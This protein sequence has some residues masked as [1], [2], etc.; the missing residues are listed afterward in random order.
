MT[1]GFHPTRCEPCIEH[2]EPVVGLTDSYEF[3]AA[4]HQQQEKPFSHYFHGKGNVLDYILASAHFN[5]DCQMSKVKLL[6]YE[7]YAAHL[8]PTQSTEDI[9]VSDHSAIAIKIHF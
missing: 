6:E 3:S 1:Q 4:F 8:N 9:S 7:S 5:P 2:N